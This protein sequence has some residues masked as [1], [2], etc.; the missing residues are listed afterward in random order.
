[1]TTTKNHA[2]WVEF[3]NLRVTRTQ[4]LAMAFLES[5]GLRF[6]VDFGT[7]NAIEKAMD[8]AELEMVQ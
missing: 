6:M 5:K 3:L 8:F 2:Y 7:D 4:R 1:M